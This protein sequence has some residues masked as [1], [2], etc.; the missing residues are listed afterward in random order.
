MVIKRWSWRWL[1]GN[2]A[3][4]AGAAAIGAKGITE[5][6]DKCELING[7]WTLAFNG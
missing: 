2:R 5:K 4:L 6:E 3:G 1:F 7:M